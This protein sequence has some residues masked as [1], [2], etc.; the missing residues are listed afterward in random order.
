MHLK[1]KSNLIVKKEPLDKM[2]IMLKSDLILIRHLFK[3]M[4]LC[5]LAYLWCVNSAKIMTKYYGSKSRW[6]GHYIGM[7]YII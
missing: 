2:P 6:V 1:L 4:P 7:N 5:S 3:S